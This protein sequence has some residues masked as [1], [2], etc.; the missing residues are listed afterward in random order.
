VPGTF[1]DS[2]LVLVGSVALLLAVAL[3]LVIFA[4]R[5]RQSIHRVSVV[6]AHVNEQSSFS[7]AADNTLVEGIPPWA[8]ASLVQW[9]SP[10]LNAVQKREYMRFTLREGIPSTDFLLMAE[11]RLRVNLDWQDDGGRTAL[12]SLAKRMEGNDEFFLQV[13]ELAIEQIDLGYTWQDQE[14]A[15]SELD[16][17]LTEA[18]SAWRVDIQRIETEDYVFG[19]LRKGYR[20]V[21]TLQRRASETA[22]NALTESVRLAPAAASHLASAWNYA[23]GRNPDPGRAYSEAIKAVEAAAGPVVSPN[24]TTATLGKVLGQLRSTPQLWQVVLAED[25]PGPAANRISPVQVVTNVAALLWENQTDRHAPVQQPI[26][27]AQAELA[28]HLAVTLVQIFSRSISR[29]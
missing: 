21:R 8:R 19:Q 25:V 20:E 1:G 13:L 18:G 3:T 14:S 2:T 4:R 29:R 10:I 11:R 26:Q 22:T 24:D 16:R 12:L 5:A 7:L 23:F 27:Q 9:L 17:I 6:E 15:L 28:V